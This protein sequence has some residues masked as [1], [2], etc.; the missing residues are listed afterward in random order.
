MV[1]QL[2]YL[3]LQHI[4]QD[5]GTRILGM[6]ACRRYYGKA[7]FN[8]CVVRY[9]LYQA[10]GARWTQPSLHRHY[11]TPYLAKVYQLVLLIFIYILFFLQIKEMEQE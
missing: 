3:R 11:S 4:E 7:L 6:A 9:S 2:S 8:S 1:L 5:L 10:H